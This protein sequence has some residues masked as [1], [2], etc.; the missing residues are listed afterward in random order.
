MNRPKSDSS[1]D[2]TPP[3]PQSQSPATKNRGVTPWK[4]ILPIVILIAAAFVGKVIVNSK[5]QPEKKT[6]PP[7]V[8]A[9]EVV[10]V[11]P[12]TVR[13]SVE[14]QGTV[15]PRMETQLTAE[16]AGRI[17]SVSPNFREGGII[18]KGE[19]L[20]QIET[21]DYEAALANAQ[22]QL[23]QAKFTL[24]Q[25]QAQSEQA[26]ADWEDLGR[27]D[28][29]DLAL[30]KPQL[31]QAQ[32]MIDSSKAGVIR[33]E[34]NLERTKLRAPYDGRV[35]AQNVD[36]GQYVGANTVIGMIYATDVAEVFLPLSSHEL[37]RLDLPSGLDAND[38][39]TG[40][41]VTLST[42]YGNRRYTWE[43]QIIRTGAQF[44]SRSR[45]LDVVVE[46]TDPLATDRNQPGRPP[47]KPGTYVEAQIQGREVRDAYS[48]PRSALREGDTVLIAKADDTLTQREVVVIQ[49]DT[50]KAV[51][52][53]GLE[54][55]DRVI[56]SPVEYVIEG[57]KLVIDNGEGSAS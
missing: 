27:G 57:M 9:V 14:S 7:R 45:L 28:P 43:G 18:K 47:L 52:S 12:E 46:I 36:L 53:E 16:V 26:A 38:D 25:E 33:A 19:V 15:R 37:G 11:Q 2:K 10:N 44:D 5:P 17:E 42:D 35:I 21:V 23:A 6:P 31:E 55:G 13:L 48:I 20:I 50:E 24:A 49:A 22:A 34:R 40:P 54:P 56:T 30:R 32:A 1:V 8:V 29:S 51:I 39:I 41:K 3:L 4:I